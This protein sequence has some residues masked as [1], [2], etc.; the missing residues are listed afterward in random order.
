MEL[1]WLRCPR[2][3]GRT[4]GTAE[5]RDLLDQTVFGQ[6]H[7]DSGADHPRVSTSGVAAPAATSQPPPPRPMVTKLFAA[8]GP[9]AGQELLLAIG[10]TKIGKSPREEP[11]AHL[12]PIADPYMSKD[13][14]AIE[15]GPGGVVLVDLGS[16][17]G[18]VVNGERVQ[19]VLLRAGD[20]VR[21]GGSTFRVVM[22][23]ASR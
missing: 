10:R 12:V 6:E 17:N 2:C 22:E 5:T 9:V 21:L 13:H 4:G 15:A 8:S 18:T 11:N 16:T 7:G 19:R 14:V 3:T 20:E 1:E 23:P